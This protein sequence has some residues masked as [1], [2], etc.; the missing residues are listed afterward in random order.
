[1]ETTGAQQ[2]FFRHIK[3]L[4]P[5][6]ISFVDEVAEVLNIS[7]D[8]AYRRIRGEKPIALEEIK[9]LCV[10]Y[11][12]SLDQ[13]LHLNSE[14]VIFS[15]KL[16]HAQNFNFELY[17]QDFLRQHEIINSFEQKELLILSKD[18][19]LYHYY[20]FPELAAFKYFFWMKTIL[21]YPDYSKT[22]F[23]SSMMTEN[24]MKT[25]EKILATY[26]KIPSTEIWNVENIN[27][28]LRQIEYYKETNVFA[29]KDDVL[30][31]YDCLERTID[32]VELQAEAGHKIN[33]PD[34]SSQKGAPLNLYIN[35]FILGDNT[36]LPILNGRKMV[37]LTHTFLNYIN[38]KDVAFAEYTY[39]HFQNILHK[40]T[41]ISIVGEKER[42]RFFNRIR[43]NIDA[44]KTAVLH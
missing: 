33:Q 5:P 38:T 28:T 24:L 34:K 29:S 37:F 3:E 32:H 40:S 10:K 42:R 2:V 25:G 8:S 6:H 36:Y 1:M 20:N 21:H 11:K 39:E 23:N 27:T 31:I 12:I 18:V 41:L 22:I 9:K 19:P 17:L 35:D 43:E 4:L 15:G 14:S 16:A 30:K 44:R 13:L 7:K 26:N